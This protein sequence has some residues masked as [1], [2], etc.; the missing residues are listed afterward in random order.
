MN[1]FVIIFWCRFE[2]KTVVILM[3]FREMKITHTHTQQYCYKTNL[4]RGSQLGLRDEKKIG[5]LNR[6]TPLNV[7]GQHI[8]NCQYKLEF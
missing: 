3:K 1:I 4:N 6:A 2:A 8:A 5:I 7:N